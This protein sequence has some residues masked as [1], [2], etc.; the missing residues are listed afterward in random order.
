MNEEIMRDGIHAVIKGRIDE[1]YEET[2]EEIE[3]LLKN[4]EQDKYEI[5]A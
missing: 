2:K 4:A 1:M 5:E 3:E